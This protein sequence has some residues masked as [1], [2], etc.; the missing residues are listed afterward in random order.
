[1]TMTN[2]IFDD[3]YTGDRYT[4]GLTH[5]P[6]ALAHVPDGWIIGSDREHKDFP[7]F[8]TV[9]YPRPLTPG[10]CDRYNLVPV[11]VRH[12][13]HERTITITVT[14]DPRD[15]GLEEPED[16]HLQELAREWVLGMTDWPLADDIDI[17]V[18][19]KANG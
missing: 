14:F 12:P 6:L 8:G 4:Y 19:P 11:A 9:Q 10:E 16:D 2:L 5:R 18:Q 7:V 17:A 3:A 15:Y 13:E 1:M